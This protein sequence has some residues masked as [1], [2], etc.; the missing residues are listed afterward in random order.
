MEES[1]F[2]VVER[3][4]NG[5]REDDQGRAEKSY[6]LVRSSGEETTF[7]FSRSFVNLAPM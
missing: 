7:P 5:I 4:R 2:N 6:G 1:F 3:R